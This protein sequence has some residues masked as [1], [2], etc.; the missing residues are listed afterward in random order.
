MFSTSFDRSRLMAVGGSTD[1]RV[2]LFSH[3]DEVLPHHAIAAAAT[4]HEF[5]RKD[6]PLDIEYTFGGERRTLAGYLERNEVAGLLVL[7]DGVVVNQT[8]RLGIGSETRFHLW[9]ATKSFTS[10]LIGRAVHDGVIDSLDDPARKY[11]ARLDG[12]PYGD[13]ALRH[14]LM[15]SSG[16]AFHHHE[17]LPNRREMYRQ[18]WFE[19]RDLDEFAAELGRRVPP[20]TDFN[21]LA[22]DTHVL[23]MALRGAYG[24]PF[25][26]IVQEELWDRLGMAGAAFWSQHDVGEGGHAFGHACLCPRLLEFAHLGQLYVQDGVWDGTRLLPEGFVSASGSPHGPFQEPA[27]GRRGYGYQ[28]WVPWRSAGEMI[29]LGAFGQMLWVD[30][31]RGVSV[32]QVGV[33]AANADAPDGPPAEV[34]EDAHAAMRAIVA[35][36]A[37]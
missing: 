19:G 36:T 26:R 24:R 16:I 32:A 34:V 11:V 1:E 21:Y 2:E 18:I 8:Y 4:P 17:G 10:T 25:H 13:V 27:E 31:E 5:V 28:W 33:D 3:W 20:G 12:R 29:A 37:R 35:A 22:T 23:S 9:S 15:M 7:A 14:L 6:D 30:L